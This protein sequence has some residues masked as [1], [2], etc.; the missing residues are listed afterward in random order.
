MME[1]PR[2]RE[3][4]SARES[5]SEKSCVEVFDG[6]LARKESRVAQPLICKIN[7]L[8]CKRDVL[9]CKKDLLICKRDV[10]ICKRD[11]VI[12]KRDL[13]RRA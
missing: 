8:T 1:L 11:L 7:P 9:I 12:C 4:E 2:E 3:I 6:L 5:E 10:L 13:H